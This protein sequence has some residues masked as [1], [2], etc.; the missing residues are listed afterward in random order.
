MAQLEQERTASFRRS[1]AGENG[2][3]FVLTPKA[4]VAHVRH[5]CTNYHQLL[6]RLQRGP[7]ATVAYLILKRR[8]NQA[9]REKLRPQ[10][11]V[12]LAEAYP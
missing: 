5:T 3:R 11:G 1:C 12:S 2:D 10:Y 4:G 9:V 8:V 7:G 6:N